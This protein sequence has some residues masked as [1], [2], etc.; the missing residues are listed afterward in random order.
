LAPGR[1]ARAVTLSRSLSFLGLLVDHMTALDA[2]SRAAAAQ[3]SRVAVFIKIDCGYGRAGVRPDDPIMLDLARRIDGDPWL[4]LAGVLTHGGHAYDCV[5]VASI[6]VVAE[7][8]RSMAVQAA[9]LIRESGIEVPVVSVGSTPTCAVVEDLTGV[10]EIRP[11]NYALF[12]V[13]QSVIGACATDDIAVGVLT[14]IIG[15]YPERRSLIVDA[16]AL[17][18]SKDPGATHV[19][20]TSGFG[21]IC[22]PDG[23]PIPG[24]SLTGLSQEHGK[25]KVAPSLDLSD[26]TVGDRLLIRPNHSCLVTALHPQLYVTEGDRVVDM[27]CPVR[28]W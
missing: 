8:E 4:N 11:G 1:A 24:L 3:E 2:L 25:V 13:F 26:L 6:R 7:E 14:E 23:T 19:D 20:P 16:G 10:T 22:Q 28:G 12:D 5:D 27:W 17:A 21:L 15:V 18:M 9:E